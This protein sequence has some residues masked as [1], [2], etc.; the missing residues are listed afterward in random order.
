M[1]KN[2]FEKLGVDLDTLSKEGKGFFRGFISEYSKNVDRFNNPVTQRYFNNLIATIMLEFHNSYENSDIRTLYRIKSPKSVLDKVLD[3]L[4]RTEKSDYE[5]NQ[6][7]EPQGRLKEDL[8][9]MFAM[10]IVGCNR[11]PIFYS[12][13][14]EIQ[15]LIKEQNKNHILLGE[16]QKYKSRLTGS[17]FS[18]GTKRSYKFDYKVGEEPLSREEYYVYCMSLIEGIK[19]LINP[20]ATKLLKKYDD[21]LENIRA[22]VPEEFIELAEPFVFEEETLYPRTTFDKRQ[23]V[24]Q[25][26]TSHIY[27]K[28]DDAKALVEMKKDITEKDVEVVDFLD[29]IDDFSARIHDKLDLVVL[30]KQVEATFADS[31]L[32]KQFGV[33]IIPDSLKQKRTEEGYV[34]DF[35]YLGTPFG[36]VEMQ[37]QT[38]HENQEASYGYAA[39]CDMDGKSFKE[40]DIPQPGN[41]QQLK[42]FRTCV[43]FVS[44]KKFIAQFDNSEKNRVFI[45]VLGK[46]QN[47]KAILT[48]VK[49]GSENEMRLTEYFAQLYGSRNEI[50][51]GEAEQER[52][53]SFIGYDIQE[54]I[55]SEEFKEIMSKDTE[56]EDR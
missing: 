31:E 55:Q 51:P 46:Y 27:K 28:A 14:P 42:D 4:S 21:M 29:L 19:S 12:N 23:I 44:A 56:K 47:Y 24:S 3:Y 49:K 39:H 45:Q 33:K 6:F 52:I 16:M 13:D 53:E 34:S 22:N 5:I 18:S 26:S 38:Q 20:N 7:G 17:E 40:F 36:K 30:R 32:L 41:E 43:E 1:N 2:I 10:T 15:E 9:D 8:S 37:L 35:I 25:I 11:P 48:Q 54:Y 50:F